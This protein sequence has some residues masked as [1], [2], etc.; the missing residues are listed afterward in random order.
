MLT[1]KTML[2]GAQ[3]LQLEDRKIGIN[4][5]SRDKRVLAGCMRCFQT[6][7]TSPRCICSTKGGQL[8][9]CGHNRSHTG[10]YQ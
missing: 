9:S 4:R 2:N 5:K 10:H 8:D 7:N 3:K 6:V 1:Q